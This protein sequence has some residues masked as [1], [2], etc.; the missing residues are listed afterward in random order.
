MANADTVSAQLAIAGY[1][2]IALHRRDLPMSIGR[3]L[4]EA[5][6]LNMSLGPGGEILRLWG[7]RLSEE[8]RAE[9]GAA[10]TDG[11]RQFETDDGVA[12]PASVWVIAARNPA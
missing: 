4:D 12:A 11:L 3:D 9:I 7:D 10:I 8:K 5:V 6:A 1:T 2:D